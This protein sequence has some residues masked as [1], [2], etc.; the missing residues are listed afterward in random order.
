MA[1]ATVSMLASSASSLQTYDANV[2]RSAKLQ[3]AYEL[4]QDMQISINVHVKNLVML[5]VS[6][7]QK[8]L[9]QYIKEVYGTEVLRQELLQLLEDGEED[10][11]MTFRLLPVQRPDH[12]C[13]CPAGNVE[14][15]PGAVVALV[16]I[17]GCYNLALPV[18]SCTSC[19]LMW[20]PSVKDILGSGYWPG[21]L[22][23][24]TLFS[25]DVFQSFYDIK[26]AAPGMSLK[27]FVKMLDERTAHFGRLSL[28]PFS[29]SEQANFE[30]VFIEKDEEV[31]EFMKYIQRHTNDHP[32][33]YYVP[34]LRC[35]LSNG[36]VRFRMG[37]VLQL[38]K[39]WDKANRHADPPG[40]GVDQKESGTTGP[41]FEPEISQETDQTDGSFGALQ[42]RLEELV[43]IIRVRTQSL[44]RQ[45]DSNKR[46][47]RIRKVILDEKKRLAAAVDDYNKLAEPTK[48]TF[49][50]GRAQVNTKR[51]VFEKVMAVR[52]LREEEMILCREMRHH[53]TVLRMRSVVLGTISSDSS[54]VGMSED[55]QKGLHSLVLK[56][57]SELKAEMLKIKDTYKRI[58]SHQPL[59]EMDSEEEEDIPDD[60]TESDLSTS[61]ED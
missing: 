46:R 26:K 18:V 7:Q 15:S 17:N 5:P 3:A 4:P 36:E 19:G 21:T 54:L 13:D 38:E 25:M 44:Y 56:K 1:T 16:T 31:A 23:F 34:L 48:P 6:T 60:A 50:P 32:R 35:G 29:T 2:N 37:P 55:A 8:A 53:W 30:G 45:N 43:V 24:C 58:L 28:C 9:S 11:A 39:R 27:A 61:D 42:A 40:F 41:Q 57:Q 14:V 52:R 22:N 47:H 51:K 12:V 20:S 33:T 49:G 10:A 59:L